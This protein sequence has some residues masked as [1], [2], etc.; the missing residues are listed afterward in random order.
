MHQIVFKSMLEESE[1]SLT[2][3]DA[4]YLSTVLFLEDV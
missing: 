1:V 4:I 2:L 3:V